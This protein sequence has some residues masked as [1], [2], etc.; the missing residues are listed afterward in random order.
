MR[1]K[2]PTLRTNLGGKAAVVDDSSSN[3]DK[4]LFTG[5]KP[6]ASPTSIDPEPMDVDTPPANHTV[7]QFTTAKISEKLSEPLKRPAESAS[8]SPADTTEVN[9]SLNDLKIKDLITTLNFPQVPQPPATPTPS[10]L[11]SLSQL[12]YDKYL[13]R[14]GK[15]I[16]EWDQYSAKFLLH[17]L[18]RKNVTADLGAKRWTD[19]V[20]TEQY[21]LGLKEDQA[22]LVKWQESMS[23]HER[24]V[25]EFCI[26][27]ERMKGRVGVDTGGASVGKRASP[28]KK[29]H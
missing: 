26:V 20:T 15:Y 6:T 1:K 10:E 9:L 2:T 3:E 25:R 4:P 24:V 29:T 14:Y 17:L 11:A 23:E 21:R 8:A 18:A 7:P 19:E 13:E 16:S 27:R 22:V 28:R 12:T 5:R